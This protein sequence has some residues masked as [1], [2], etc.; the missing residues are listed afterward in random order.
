MKSNTPFTK[1]CIPKYYS[2]LLREAMMSLAEVRESVR[3]RQRVKERMG[4]GVKERER[5][6]GIRRGEIIKM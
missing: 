4:V 3:V 5:D 1:S 6:G 2:S